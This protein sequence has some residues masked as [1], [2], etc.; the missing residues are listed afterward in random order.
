MSLRSSPLLILQAGGTTVF[1]YL[2]F[3]KLN[4][5]IKNWYSKE[6]WKTAIQRRKRKYYAGIGFHNLSPEI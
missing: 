6:V 1:S 3:N 4:R 2:F 5:V